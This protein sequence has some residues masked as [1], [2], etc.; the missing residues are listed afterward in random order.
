MKDYYQILGVHREASEAEIKRAYRKLVVR[1]HPDKNKETTAQDQI[2]EINEAY[3]VLG[4]TE[5]RRAYDMGQYKPLIDAFTVPEEP[6]VHRD[7]AYRRRRPTANT[8][9]GKPT[10]R[11]LIEHYLPLFVKISLVAF[12]FCML[13]LI[14]Y[15]LPFKKSLEKVID[16]YYYKGYRT[17]RY[18]SSE[19]YRVIVTNENK[20]Y[21]VAEADLPVKTGDL[22]FISASR[23]LGVPVS[24]QFNAGE[25]WIFR[26]TIYQNF[27]FMPL[28]LLLTS[29]V[30]VFWKRY[31]EL[32]FNLGIINGILLILIL[33]F[34]LTS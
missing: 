20:K 10:M 23:L 30:G 33:F 26:S 6:R 7:P 1:Y 2:R 17:G 3:E 11:D 19:A 4:D 32:R 12:C 8:S 24:I 22:I 13:L 28:I 21:K 16:T 29:A 9:V 18:G 31:A 34:L 27:V 15:T 25:R 5:K 14:D